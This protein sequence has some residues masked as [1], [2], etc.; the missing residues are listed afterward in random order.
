MFL[1]AALQHIFCNPEEN[2]AILSIKKYN[3]NKLE[4]HNGIFMAINH[5]K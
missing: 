1:S 3:R 4:N 5:D 2:G